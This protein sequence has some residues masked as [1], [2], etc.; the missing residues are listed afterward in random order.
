MYT[1]CR[2]RCWCRWYVYTPWD[3]LYILYQ[4]LCIYRFY[5]Y[6]HVCVYKD[7]AHSSLD[8]DFF[9]VC[10]RL[11]RV[12][13]MRST[14][15]S[16][17]KFSRFSPKMP[18]I[19]LLLTFQCSCGIVILKINP[20]ATLLPTHAIFSCSLFLS[21]VLSLSLSL[22]LVCIWIVRS[23][24]FVARVLLTCATAWE[25]GRAEGGKGATWS[26][27]RA[28]ASWCVKRDRV[29]ITLVCVFRDRFVYNRVRT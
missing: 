20:A 12:A 2:C 23:L 1:L 24:S 28:T 4:Y 25:R 27:A 18:N 17:V 29:E 3:I 16:S 14:G 5:V 6:F 13:S 8:T 19:V 15:C 22:A 7:F 26:G 9:A 21:C 10:C 11:V